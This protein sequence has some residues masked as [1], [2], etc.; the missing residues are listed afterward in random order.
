[1]S[2][3]ADALPSVE[4]LRVALVGA[5]GRMG[6]FAAALLERQPDFALV[7]RLGRGDALPE[8]FAACEAQLGLDLTV[9]G[10]GA[11]HARWM[12]EAG[13]RPV[14]GTSGVTP[15]ELAELDASA[16]ARGLGG[17]VVPNFSLG[18]ALV[19]RVA[20]ELARALPAVEIVELHHDGKR[21]APSGSAL[22]TR[23]R[24]AAVRAP[25]APAIP[26]HS[27]RLPGLRAHQELVFGAPGETVTLRHDTSSQECYAQGLLAA[28]RHAAG[29]TGVRCGLE[30]A[31][32]P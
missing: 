14:I 29:A 4:P 2:P 12:L 22:D 15:A 20:L 21:D 9:A 26:I 25:D 19:Q 30:H 27:V 10:L 32:A 18:M 1:M 23:R 16:R 24:L 7:A 6:R 17:L 8:A 28:L 3:E 13:L 5:R 11:R 31:L